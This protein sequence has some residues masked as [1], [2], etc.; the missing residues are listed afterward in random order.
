MTEMEGVI[1]FHKT[2]M[3]HWKLDEDQEE[4]DD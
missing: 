4:E 1:N 3:L 2:R